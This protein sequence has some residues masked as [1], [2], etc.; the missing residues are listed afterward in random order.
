MSLSRRL[1]LSVAAIVIA[2]VASV[3]LLE[4]RAYER[5]ID[6]DL[7]SSAR[8]AAQSAADAIEN[9]GE[10]LDPLEI[11][12]TLHDLI[13]AD[14]AIDAISLIAGDENGELR[15]V[16][17]TTTE[18]RAETID[19]ARQVLNTGLPAG[20]RGG[21]LIFAVPVPNQARHVMSVTVGL[22]SL[23]QARAHALY[24]ALGFALPT[25]LLVTA[26]VHLTV[27]HFVELPLRGLLQT[28]KSAAGGD[29]QARA[30][31]TRSDELGTIAAGLNAMLDQL[32]GFHRTL[33]TRIDEA[34]HDL[35]VRNAQLAQ[36]RDALFSA[37]ESLARAER[38]AALGQMA[39]NIAHQAGTPLN[40]VSGYVQML[41]DDPTLDD[42]A[43]AKLDTIDKQIQQVARVLRTMLDSARAPSGFELVEVGAIIDRVREV[44]EP[45]LSRTNIALQ[46]SVAAGLPSIRADITQLEMILL[47][48]LTN[49]LDA[50]PGGGSVTLAASTNGNGGV[51]IEVSDTGPGFPAEILGRAFESWVTTKPAGQGSGLGLA[52]VRDVV[53][54]HGGSVSAYNR[55]V[56]ASVA[57]D[58][59]GA[60]SPQRS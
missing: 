34:T 45:R 21:V 29:R 50:M 9:R 52:I 1:S 22:E 10:P 17:S 39:A 42:R 36:S 3:A 51:R 58:L 46:T 16:T 32:D 6:S 44:A 33:Q 49:A 40:L 59:P 41:R 56:G 11:R 27:R 26:L 23:Q 60:G 54:T 5:E 24:L 35:S 18:E 2:V 20:R 8:L 31:A 7:E 14:P 57:I 47:N 38:V 53:R 28:M 19:L 25:M 4:M 13:E 12:D 55:D 15:V 48:L 37:R 43:R 30:L